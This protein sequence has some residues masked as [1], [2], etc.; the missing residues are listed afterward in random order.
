MR[1]LVCDDDASVREF[2][3]AS[4]DVEGWEVAAVESGEDCLEVIHHQQPP[5]VIVLDQAMPGL[6]GTQVA[7]QLREEG[8]TRP[9]VLCSSNLAAAPKN[10]IERLDLLTVNKIDVPAVV[11]IAHAAVL[12]DQATRP[13]EPRY[14]Q[15]WPV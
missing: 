2:L 6:Q 9:I 13:P 15:R 4:F 14:R 5:D 8:F 12:E 11:R 3:A 7:D 10:D 1:V